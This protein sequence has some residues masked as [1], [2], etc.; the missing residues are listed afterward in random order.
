MHPWTTDDPI[1]LCANPAHERCSIAQILRVRPWAPR[2][3]GGSLL[4]RNQSPNSQS[5]NSM[6]TLNQFLALA[7]IALALCLSTGQL[8]AQGR[9]R[10]NQGQGRGG[11]NRGNFDPA[12]ARQRMLDGYKDRLEI[13]NDDEWKII[14]DRV[15]K[16]LHPPRNPR[17]GWW[18]FPA[19]AAVGAVAAV[20]PR[21]PITTAADGPTAAVFFFRT[22]T[23][24]KNRKARAHPPTPPRTQKK[25]NPKSPNN[26]NPKN[27]PG[28]P[29][30][31]PA[32]VSFMFLP[33]PLDIFIVLWE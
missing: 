8:A 32:K 20:T 13:T 33:C 14:Q 27:P 31:R 11:Q 10:G 12:Q 22:R 28:R 21:K 3:C 19:A 29:G 5:L 16:I 25:K 2:N 6:K 4:R 1:K 26:S 23:H 15:E 18:G 24:P 17:R 7:G 9:Q 30:G